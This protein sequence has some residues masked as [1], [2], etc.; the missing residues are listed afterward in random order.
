MANRANIDN[1]I[2]YI[3][4]VD[5]EQFANIMDEIFEEINFEI[6]H[7]DSDGDSGYA[8]DR[9]RLATERDERNVGASESDDLVRARATAKMGDR[10]FKEYNARWGPRS[11]MAAEIG[12]GPRP[13]TA[14]GTG[15][16]RDRRRTALG[17]KPCPEAAAGSGKSRLSAANHA[18]LTPRHIFT[19][20][21]MQVS[22]PP[23]RNFRYVMSQDIPSLPQC[24]PSPS[25][26]TSC[27]LY[28][29]EILEDFNAQLWGIQK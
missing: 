12:G 21:R 19:A 11:I 23:L 13:E 7:R 3:R 9:T 29:V 16:G 24:H 2:H 25:D 15:G 22:T 20:T 4:N 1:V 17:D 8:S 10:I 26:V 6:D 27:D 28:S 18:P 14:I 5:P